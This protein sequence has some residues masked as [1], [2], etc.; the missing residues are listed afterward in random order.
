MTCKLNADTSDGL[1]IVSDT[2][3]E[4]DLQIYAS[5]K[6]HMASDG[7]VG[8]GT[9][10]PAQMLHVK[11]S[12]AR[13]RTEE[14]SG[15]TTFEMTNTSSGHF[16]DSSGTNDLTINKSGSANLVLKTANTVRHIIDEEGQFLF[17]GITDELTNNGGCLQ[18]KSRTGSEHCATFRNGVS[19]GGFGINFQKVDG[20][21]VGSIA[22]TSSA[23]N[24]NTSSDYRLKENVNYT[25]DA[26]TEVKKLK[27]CKFNFK[28]ES[29]T[30]EGFLAHEVSDV[31][32][33]AVS[34]TK[35]ETR[36]LGTVKDADGNVIRENVI[37][38]SKEDGQTWSKTSTENVYQSIDQSKL[39]PL[40]VKTIQ[41]LEARITALESK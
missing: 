21:Q 24:F 19:D 16:L 1:K 6:V 3:G 7:K 13:I 10:S 22:W 15:S 20:T 8:I 28:D 26:T 35:D 29:D 18:L 37:E 33:L 11:A 39:V 14:S 9:T 23:T 36:D 12:D 32:P 34:G 41:E 17:G 40:L 27:P 38:S 4:I 25:F 31:V 2:S 5:T 30:V